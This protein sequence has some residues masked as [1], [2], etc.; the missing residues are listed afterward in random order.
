MKK[1]VIYIDAEDEIT[2]ITSKLADSSSPIV[3]LVLPKRCQVLQSAVNLKILNK[4]A[5]QNSKKAVLITSDPVILQLAGLTGMFVA[6]TL[7]SKPYVPESSE[8]AVVSNEI[9]EISDEDS[10]T[11]PETSVVSPVQATDTKKESKPINKAPKSAK[12]KKNKKL[13]VPN[14]DSFRSKLF[15]AAGLI[16]VIVF[17]VVMAV[18]VL[19]KAEITVTAETQDTQVTTNL[20]AVPNKST[21]DVDQKTFILKTNTI[22]K[23][24]SKKAAATGEKNDGAKAS[25]KITIYNCDFKDGFT[26]PAGSV[27]TTGFSGGTASFV[28]SDAVSVPGFSSNS[29]RDCKLTSP[30]TN[31]GKASVSVT[32][33]RPG[34]QYN[35]SSG[36]TYNVPGISDV[37]DVVAIGDAMGGGSDKITKIIAQEDCDKAKNEVQATIASGDYQKQLTADFEKEGIIPSIDTFSSKV[38]SVVCTPQAGSPGEEVTATAKMQFTMSGVDSKAL[39]QLVTKLALEKAGPDQTVV[40]TGLSKATLTLL[41]KKSD[42]S[43]EFRLSTVAL[44]TI[45]QDTEAIASSVKGKNARTTADTIKAINGVRDVSVKY[46]PFWVNKTPTN[47]KKINIVFINEQSNQ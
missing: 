9:Q 31:A 45:K 19:P 30:Y 35:L 47:T 32:S 40:D 1:D 6:S 38:V 14:F 21:D 3:A 17:V 42:G 10:H 27:F 4:T 41:Q 16:A 26:I 23:S 46:S 44:V 2:A 37:N 24:D 7:Q 33:S 22:E 29:I 18:F 36:R 12:P 8:K 25:G 11:E 13:K 15:L 39:E 43:M 5:T 20:I 34:A 28:S